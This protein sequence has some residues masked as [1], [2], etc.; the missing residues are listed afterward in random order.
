MKKRNA[1]VGALIALLVLGGAFL[2]YRK[3]AQPPTEQ[4]AAAPAPAAPPGVLR[5]AVGAPQLAYIRSEPAVLVPEP[6]LEPLNARV[7][8]DENHTA[9][10]SSPIAG[11]VVKIAVLP[12]DKVTAGQALAWLDAP[13]YS[14]ARADLAKAEAD[15]RLK[16]TNFTRAKELY[17]GGVV[18]LKDYQSA[19][20][21]LKQ[22]EAEVRR[23]RGR[24]RNLA[25][26][27]AGDGDRFAL[28][29]PIAGVVTERQLNPGAQVRP[30]NPNPLFVITDPAHLWVMVDLPER[31]LAKVK[32]GQALAVDVDAYRGDSFAGQVEYVGDVLDPAT[33]RIQVRC[34]VDNSRGRLKPEMFARVTVFGETADP[35]LR[36]LTDSIITEGLYTYVFVEKEPG[37]FEKRRVT[38]RL[39]GRDMSYVR[40][41]LQAGDKVVVTGALLLNSELTGSD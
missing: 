1:M 23:A 32:A 28:R 20:N 33:R 6:V 18:A 19:E 7:A 4:R 38:A 31:Q 13:D 34:S 2:G 9:R 27:G 41:G 17:D 35:V 26:A 15:L 8:Y 14:G 30:D 10:I 11:R 5:F 22:D 24:I 29:A 16:Q 36:I 12:G 21:D 39:Q 40:N 25:A 3:L 37:V